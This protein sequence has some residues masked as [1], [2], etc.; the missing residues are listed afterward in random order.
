MDAWSFHAECHHVSVWL[1]DNSV[2]KC[3]LIDISWRWRCKSGHST[4]GSQSVSQP[5]SFRALWAV[6]SGSLIMV[7]SKSV[8]VRNCGRHCTR[9]FASGFR[10]SDTR[11][12][13]WIRRR[14][15]VAAAKR[16]GYEIHLGASLAAAQLDM[17]QSQSPVGPVLTTLGT[18]R[19]RS[20][21]R[22]RDRGGQ[23]C[24]SISR[25]RS[26]APRSRRCAASRYWA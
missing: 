8:P 11:A 7:R 18:R 10:R 3:E 6:Q 21:Y 5:V 19:R 1:L 2:R 26:P 4:I 17:S 12:R 24:G 22:T 13:I 20:E 23:R 9:E 25:Q 15:Q 14:P 16:C